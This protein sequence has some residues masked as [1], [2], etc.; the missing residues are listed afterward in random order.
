MHEILSLLVNPVYT[1]LSVSLEMNIYRF[2]SNLPPSLLALSHVAVVGLLQFNGNLREENR[3]YSS[4]YNIDHYSCQ[5]L[6][7]HSWKLMI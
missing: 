3:H 1:F 6:E 7:F 5:S 4:S 2:V